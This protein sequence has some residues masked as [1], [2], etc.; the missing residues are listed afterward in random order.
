VKSLLA[1]V[2]GVRSTEVDF[3][4]KTV[5][6]TVDPATF[7]AKAAFEALASNFPG[8]TFKKDAR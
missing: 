7:K 5:T 6:C 4:K 1:D 3:E 2:A 8:T